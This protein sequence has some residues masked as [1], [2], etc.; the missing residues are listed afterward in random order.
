[1][2]WF[3]RL[4]MSKVLCKG[5]CGIE[6]TYKGWCKIKWKSGNRFAVSCPIVE[7]KRGKS[8]SD[9]R[10]E[11]AK[12]GKNPMQNPIIC[13]KN[14]SKERNRKCGETLRKI[15]ELGLLPQQKENKK[16]KEKRKK[17]VSISL[18]KLWKMGKHPRQL[19]SYEKRRERLDKM[20]NTLKKLGA[21]GKLPIQNLS[22]EKKKTRGKKISKKLR[23]GIKSGKIK[24]SKGWKKVAYKNLILRSNWEKIVAEF[25]D[26]EG[27][28]W[29]YET[30]RIPYWDTERK[31]EAITIPDFYIPSIN[32]IIEVK[33]NAE[34]SSQKTK[35]K[36]NIL[37]ER[38]FNAL[39]VGRKEIQLIK[40]NQ[41]L[42]SLESKNEK[43]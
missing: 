17:N 10:I 31:I 28:D 2:L 41:F 33:S 6:A 9:F 26:K 18:R 21:E 16:L 19:E 39:L 36:L 7:K 34:F 8:I 40:D 43:S 24:L 25:L 4:K 11:E 23:E 37:K 14:H 22:E 20:A 32:T 42:N 30:K 15:G 1:M 12:K 35:D 27:F 38:G 29:E 3:R 13:A 5:G